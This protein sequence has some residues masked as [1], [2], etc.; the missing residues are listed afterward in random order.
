MNGHTVDAKDLVDFIANNAAILINNKL[1]TKDI[2]D[3]YNEYALKFK[4]KPP[5][6]KESDENYKWDW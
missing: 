3:Y 6:V 4:L 1:I 2:A 5:F